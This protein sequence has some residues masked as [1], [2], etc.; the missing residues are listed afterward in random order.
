M[1]VCR[2]F[3]A[4]PLPLSYAFSFYR[5]STD[6]K[7]SHTQN[8]HESVQ[9]I[10]SYIFLNFITF[11]I[12]VQNLTCLLLMEGIIHYYVWSS[13]KLTYNCFICC[14]F[15]LQ[16]KS[17]MVQD[18]L[19]RLGESMVQS[20]EGTRAVALELC[21]EFEDKF[22]AHITSGE[23]SKELQTYLDFNHTFLNCTS[24]YNN[25][26]LSCINRGLVGKLLQVLKG[27]SQRELNSCHWTGTL[28][29]AMLKG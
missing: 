15:S 1:S 12:L 21:R 2:P 20:A 28:T 24:N 27:N 18:E 26:I 11:L 17:Q 10:C 3:P 25:N 6:T 5:F 29:S 4:L 7:Y 14:Y 22:L 9:F 23:V 16:G 13:A 19:A 8:N